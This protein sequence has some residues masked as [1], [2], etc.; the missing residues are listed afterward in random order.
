MIRRIPPADRRAIAAAAV[1]GY[2]AA[3][4]RAGMR[5][6]AKMRLASALALAE[7]EQA[8]PTP[9]LRAAAA[10]LGAPVA[11]DAKGC[12]CPPELVAALRT[13]LEAAIEALFFFA[14]KGA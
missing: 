12:K 2:Q 7:L 9:S 4:A 6:S 11:D 5:G 13:I 1:T 10:E 3:E 14:T 8:G